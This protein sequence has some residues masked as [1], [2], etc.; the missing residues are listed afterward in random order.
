MRCSDVG[1]WAEKVVSLEPGRGR[2]P[3][4]QDCLEPGDLIKT[5]RSIRRFSGEPVSRE[6]VQELIDAATRAP[7]PHNRQPWRFAVLLTASKKAHLAHVMGE[8]LQADRS[9][10]G[11]PA[12]AIEADVARSRARIEGA[13]VIIVAALSMRDM[14]TYPDGRRLHAEYIMAVQATATAVQNM[15]LLAHASGLGSCWMC[16]PLFCPETVRD[17]LFLPQDWEP[18]ALVALGV[19]GSP[20]RDRPRLDPSETTMWLDEP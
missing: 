4:A 9:R 19:P 5:R 1:S 3:L 6:V 8:R 13:P 15:L 2:K 17:G 10:D 11:D 20:G 18:Q 7:S 16:A 12:E 14:D